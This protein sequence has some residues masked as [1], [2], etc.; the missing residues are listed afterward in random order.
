MG[1]GFPLGVL[2]VLELEG[3]DVADSVNVP[4]ATEFVTG[5]GL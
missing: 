1:L 3:G 5:C 2:K 4:N